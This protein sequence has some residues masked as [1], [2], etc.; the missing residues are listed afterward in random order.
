MNADAH[1]VGLDIPEPVSEDMYYAT[2]SAFDQHSISRC[3]DLKLEKKLVNHSWDK[4]VNL[5]VFGVYIVDTYNV[6]T[7][8]LEF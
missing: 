1:M 3:N 8:P 4:S 7:Q 2:F 5:I 6:A